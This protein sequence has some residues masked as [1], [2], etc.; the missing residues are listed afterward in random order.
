MPRRSHIV[1]RT[2]KDKRFLLVD[3]EYSGLIAKLQRA[4]HDHIEN[5]TKERVSSPLNIGGSAEATMSS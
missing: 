2:P 3:G 4:D 1:S 5:T